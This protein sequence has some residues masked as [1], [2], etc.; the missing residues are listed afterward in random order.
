MLLRRW[1][2]SGDRATLEHEKCFEEVGTY[3]M[4]GEVRLW[5]YPCARGRRDCWVL[6]S[7]AK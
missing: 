3:I 6:S 5:V 2:G 7:A 4:P 1:L